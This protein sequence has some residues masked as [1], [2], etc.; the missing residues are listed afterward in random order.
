MTLPPRRSR[1][2]YIEDSTFP[3][4]RQR[5]FVRDIEPDPGYEFRVIDP[6][7]EVA[8]EP[9]TWMELVPE[10]ECDRLRDALKATLPKASNRD[11]RDWREVCNALVQEVHNLIAPVDEGFAD[12]PGIASDALDEAVKAFDRFDRCMAKIDAKHEAIGGRY[13]YV[14][15]HGDA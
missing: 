14:R 11:V 7:E 9:G 15:V 8:I 4:E 2:A 1:V 10:A 12:L 5:V 6:G 3:V 13:R